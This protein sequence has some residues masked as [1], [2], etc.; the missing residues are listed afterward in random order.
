MGKN[1]KTKTD[2]TTIKVKP[3]SYQPTKAELEE[4]IHAHTTPEHAAQ[5]LTSL[6]NVKETDNP[7]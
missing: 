5:C 3:R 2:R 1:R 7:N 6:F 4:K